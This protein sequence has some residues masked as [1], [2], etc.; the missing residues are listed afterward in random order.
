[1]ALARAL[2]KKH[3]FYFISNNN[4][5]G[6]CIQS[7]KVALFYAMDRNIKEKKVVCDV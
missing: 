5:G 4:G 2:K 6:F 1:M 3:V 7:Q